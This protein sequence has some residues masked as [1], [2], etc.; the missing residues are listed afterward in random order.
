MWERTITAI[1]TTALA[2]GAEP[3]MNVENLQLLLLLF[4]SLQLMQKKQVVL[5][6]CNAL[7]KVCEER[8]APATPQYCLMLARLCLIVDYIIRHLYEP[9]STLLPQA[10][11]C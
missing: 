4:H 7:K 5:K 10:R 9:P 11:F 8:P 1:T 6:A 3:D 2:P